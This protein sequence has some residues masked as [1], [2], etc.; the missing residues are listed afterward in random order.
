MFKVGDLARRTGVSIRTLH[1][2]DEIDLLTPSYYSGAG[3]RLY[4]PEDVARLQQIKSLQALGFSLEQIRDCLQRR[5]FSPRDVIE[6][7]LRRLREQVTLQQQLCVRLEAIAAQLRKAETVSVEEFLQTI[8][9]M[10]MI[11][12]Y[13]TPEQLAEIQ[14][15][16]RQL[17]DEAIRKAEAEW[18]ELIAQ[19]RAE[20]DFGTDPA[21][22]SVQYLAARWMELLRSFSGGNPGIEQALRKMYEQEPGLRQQTGVDA[23]MAEYVGKALAAKKGSSA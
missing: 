23:A 7:H 17:G 3:H 18:K 6:Q 10:T 20:M 19:V 2:Y 4:A 9:G 13:Y 8:E 5:D 11:E 1:Y 12:K 21:A 16:G 14:E 15:R 22:E